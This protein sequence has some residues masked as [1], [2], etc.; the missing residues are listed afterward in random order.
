MGNDFDF[1]SF[2]SFLTWLDGD[3]DSAAIKYEAL[4]AHLIAFLNRRRCPESERLADDALTIFMRRLP[5]LRDKISDPRPYLTVVARNLYTEYIT[6]RHLPLPDDVNRLPSAGE[7]G[8]E[9]G[10]IFECLDECLQHLDPE[11]RE[12][13]LGYYER[14]KQQKID[15]RREMAE[16]RGV[17]PNALRLKIYHIK[18]RLRRCIEGELAR[19]RRK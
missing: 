2:N 7:E 17:T 6:T 19:P 15:F 16:E 10:R 14:E 5:H 18:A 8:D 13:F 4:R 12:L 1:E 9:E 3:R 11:E